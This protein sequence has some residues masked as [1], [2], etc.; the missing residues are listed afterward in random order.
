MRW[1]VDIVSYINESVAVV[2]DSP[3]RIGTVGSSRLALLRNNDKLIIRP[4][5]MD[6]ILMLLLDVFYIQPSVHN[7]VPA[8]SNNNAS[9][10]MSVKNCAERMQRLIQELMEL[11]KVETGKYKL[12]YGKVDIAELTSKILENFSEISEEQKIEVHSSIPT[13]NTEIVTDKNAI[14]KIMYNLISNAFKYT[15]ASGSINID[16]TLS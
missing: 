4:S 9:S 2:S 10:A 15:P 14:E 6:S 13:G 8:I 12:I 11:R 7:V 1:T 3:V 16:I 5:Y